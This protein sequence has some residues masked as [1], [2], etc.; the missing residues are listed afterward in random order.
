[1]LFKKKIKKAKKKY[2]SVVSGFAPSKPVLRPLRG[3]ISHEKTITGP[4]VEFF[5]KHETGDD[6][7]G[8]I[9][10]GGC[11]AHPN[12]MDMSHIVVTLADF[13][14]DEAT[15]LMLASKVKIN[16]ILGCS[17]IWYSGKLSDGIY[18]ASTKAFTIKVESPIDLRPRKFVSSEKFLVTL[19]GLMPELWRRVRVA[20]HGIL[21]VPI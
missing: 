20:F 16:W 13:T 7:N 1:M 17:T 14:G 12:E 19:D 8:P 3:N 2:V 9:L 15:T 18:V 4:K 6:V 21:Y 5:A 11:L 10:P